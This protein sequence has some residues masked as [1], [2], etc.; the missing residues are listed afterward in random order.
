MLKKLSTKGEQEVFNQVSPIADRYGA[1][2][3]R[4]VRIADVV[5]IERLNGR[6]L[7]TYALQAHF[8]F[9]IADESERPL[10]AV[11]FDG[12]G[13]SPSHDSKKDEICREANLALFRVNFDATRIYTVCLKFLEYLVHLWFL[14]SAFEEMRT[15][16]SVSADEPFMMSGFLKPNPKNVFDS[17]F[18]LLGHA[19]GKL[20]AACKRNNLPGGP[21][22]HFLLAEAL[23]FHDDGNYIAFCSSPLC[24]T[25]L[26]TQRFVKVEASSIRVQ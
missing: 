11:E 22:W 6:P 10:F 18:N 25:K 2:V 8:D 17:E 16:G 21:L 4:K 19:R 13:H 7:G 3:Y 24:A 1:S 15:A 26:L 9:V 14:G 5:D 23:L 12:S 20:V